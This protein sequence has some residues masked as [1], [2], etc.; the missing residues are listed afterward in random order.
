MA[1]FN[2]R[3]TLEV[4]LHPIDLDED[5]Q[6]VR[7]GLRREIELDADPEV[8]ARKRVLLQQHFLSDPSFLGSE[9]LLFMNRS[10]MGTPMLTSDEVDAPESM[11]DTKSW[12]HQMNLIARVTWETLELRSF[13]RLTS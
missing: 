7:D 9:A 12:N 10:Y 4:F 13:F 8:L 2:I 6:F 5:M 3:E 1:N 11:W